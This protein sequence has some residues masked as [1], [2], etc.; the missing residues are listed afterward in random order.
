MGVVLKFPIFPTVIVAFL[1]VGVALAQPTTQNP[2]GGPAMSQQSQTGGKEP[3]PSPAT[4]AYQDAAIKMHQDLA[5]A[6]RND[7]DKDFAATLEAH[8]IGAVALALRE[9]AELALGAR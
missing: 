3:P 6:Y 2:Q 8:H 1:V 9:L 7:A 5:V 4:L